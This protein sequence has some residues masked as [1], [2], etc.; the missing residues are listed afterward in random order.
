[1]R[2]RFVAVRAHA[3]H[4]H[5][6]RYI[7]C[8]ETK[9]RFYNVMEHCP[10]GT[11]ATYTAAR[12]G[13]LSE[14]EAQSA[15]RVL[16][17]TV[18]YL[19]LHGIVHRDIKPQNVLLRR[20]GDLGSM[21]LAD[22][23]SSHVSEDRARAL[24]GAKDLEGSYLAPEV[25]RGLPYNSAVDVWAIGCIAYELLLGEPPFASAASIAELF[26]RITAVQLPPPVP[27]VTN[28]AADFVQQL[29]RPEPG[30]RPTAAEARRH[31][32]LRLGAHGRK[33]SGVEVF[34]REESGELEVLPTD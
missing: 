2:A 33:R 25:A 12:N 11:L 21:V 27:G 31:L 5:L 23:D 22:F 15:C 14:C 18:A 13:K 26:S 3:G 32:W 34:L 19:H 7:E 28:L 29:L 20:E 4:P 30:D 24:L 10:G 16:M 8:F 1:M 17:A 6:I 9:S